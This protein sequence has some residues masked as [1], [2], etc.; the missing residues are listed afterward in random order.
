MLN[1]W[2]QTPFVPSSSRLISTMLSTLR[3]IE[4]TSGSGVRQLSF[5]PSAWGVLKKFPSTPFGMIGMILKILH[6]L[7]FSLQSV[8]RF[9][10]SWETSCTAIGHCGSSLTESLTEAEWPIPHGFKTSS[11]QLTDLFAGRLLLTSSTHGWL[12][13]RIRSLL[14]RVLEGRVRKSLS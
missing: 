9:S 7:E 2:Q 6:S 1:L 12:R 14:S 5:W 11:S 13:Q 10:D 3:I 8:N 4:F